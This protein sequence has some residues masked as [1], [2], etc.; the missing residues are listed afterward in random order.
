MNLKS[1]NANEFCEYEPSD[2]DGGDPMRP[3]NFG[4][5]AVWTRCQHTAR[6][7]RDLHS[8]DMHPIFK[9]FTFLSCL[10]IEADELH[11]L[12]IGVQINLTQI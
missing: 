9:A 2:K 11:I 1:Y 5:T 7:W 6:I 8:E 12:W 3:L 10:N 4:P